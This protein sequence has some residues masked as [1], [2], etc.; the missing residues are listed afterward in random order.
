MPGFEATTPTRTQ[1]ANLS[2]TFSP[3]PAAVN[4]ARVNYT[5]NAILM[6][7]P[8]G[9]GLGDISK[10]G[11]QT[12]GLGILPPSHTIAGIPGI[13][14]YQLGVGFGA[15][16]PSVRNE[17][18]GQVL[19]NY[20]RVKG[21][22]T[23]KVGADFRWFEAAQRIRGTNGYFWFA[24]SETGND[25]AD[26]LIGV[27]DGFIQASEEDE[28]A[29]SKYFG[30]YA[31]DSFKIRPNFTLNYGLRWE[32]S[33]P[34]SDTQGR[35]QAFVPGEQ[36]KVYPDSPTGW[37]FP[38]DP[39]IPSSLSPTRYK[40]F[41]PRLGLA[42]S[43][44]FT[45]GLAG[46]IFGG[47][48]KSSIR[49]SYGIFRTVYDEA[50]FVYETG[51]PPFG[52]YYMAPS[53]VYLEEP[54]KARATGADPGQRFPFTIPPKYSEVDFSKY[55]PISSDEI[56]G[57]DDVLPYAQHFNFNVQRQI[58]STTTLTLAYVGTVGRHLSA[59]VEANPGSTS[60]CLQIAA[61]ATASGQPG[62]GCGPYGEDTI[63]NINGQVF[64][65]TRP[66]SVTSGRGL[67]LGRLDFGGQLEMYKTIANSSYNSFQVTL[68]KKLG[69]LR[70]LA[71]YTYGK[72]L[73]DSSSIND[74]LDPFDYRLSKALSAFDMTHNFVVSYV[75]DLPFHKLTNSPRGAVTKFLEGWS[76]AGITRFTT[77]LPVGLTQSGDN[78]LVGTSPGYNGVDAPDWDGQA[79]TFSNPRSSV[80]HQWFSTSQ[81]S[82]QVL[83]DVGTASR[84]FFHGPG[85]NN[86][87]LSLL[88][89]TRLKESK[90]LEFRLEF[91]NMFNHTQFS[92]PVGEFT[93][94][95]FGQVTSAR[96]PRIGQAALKLY[97]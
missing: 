7:L 44:G 31:Q 8:S 32:F 4:E 94:A 24:G 5:R 2:N 10:Y 18:S 42:Y 45:G 30:L 87:D 54:Y 56:A 89:S 81:F 28:D 19:D 60:T 69:A 61:L 49:A 33:Q 88:K 1:Q 86:W 73:D 52:I 39:G 20:S 65:G 17:N 38:G 75:Y 50:T 71:A 90:S 72:A 46:K 78:S 23:A 59:W 55:L 12:T 67:S 6:G 76:V 70:F 66:Y 97:F 79:L 62:L 37:V 74:G 35:V 15:S 85:L 9:L 27:P 21:T 14:L 25:F 91:F 53:L 57:T 80:A 11:W 83:G 92:N 64:N 41:N 22:H 43:P 51:N 48:G 95:S 26:Y 68:D 84:R 93:S 96:A 36:S 63:Y 34:W 58:G 47:P 13:N 29:R 77:G 3:S 82:S 40:N 16:G